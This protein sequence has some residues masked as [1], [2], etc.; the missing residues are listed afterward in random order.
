MEIPFSEE[1]EKAYL[2]L[3]LQ[4]NPMVFRVDA[5]AF[6]SMA[7]RKVYEAITKTFAS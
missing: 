5:K 2:G 6:Y 3:L 7:N 1:A 4:G